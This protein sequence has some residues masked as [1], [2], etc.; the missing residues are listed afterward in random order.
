MATLRVFF[1]SVTA[2]GAMASIGFAA[3]RSTAPRPS[4]APDA[5]IAL[6]ELESRLSTRIA[7]S[8]QKITARMPIGCQSSALA[9][10]APTPPEKADSPPPSPEEDESRES[11]ESIAAF[12]NARKLLDTA[13]TRGSWGEASRDAFRNGLYGVSPA[14]RQELMESLVLAINSGRLVPSAVPPI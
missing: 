5:S 10:P 1:L 3:G 9:P 2:V 11:S 4:G 13:L 7:E 14:R 8:E 12:D 6:R